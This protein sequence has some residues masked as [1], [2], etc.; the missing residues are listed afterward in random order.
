MSTTERG[1]RAETMAAD[2]L[3]ERGLE[4]VARNWRTRWCELDVVARS[5]DGLHFVEV[6]YRANPDYGTGFDYITRDKQLRLARAVE[7]WCQH[8]RY[9][10]PYQIDVISVTGDLDRQP[11]IEWLPNAVVES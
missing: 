5:S 11:Q 7:S 4:I 9:A 6:K 8:H 1:R 10:G 3:T 2:Y